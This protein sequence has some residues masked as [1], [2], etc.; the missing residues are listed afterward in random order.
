[1]RRMFLVIILILLPAASWGDEYVLVM[2][3]DD[4]VC[5]NMLNLYN[6]DLRKYGE[7]QYN[8][9]IEFTSIKWKEKHFFSIHNGRKEYTRVLMSLFD[10]NNDEKGE[11]VLKW[12]SSLQSSPTDILYIFKNEDM[13]YFKDEFD[14]KEM[15]RAVSTLGLGGELFKS[16]AYKLKELPKILIDIDKENYYILG[17]LFFFHPFVY[18]G[19][20]YIEMR[21]DM[22]FQDKRRFLVILTYTGDNQLKDT[23]YYLRAVYRKQR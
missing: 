16:N 17:G 19:K 5:Q 18:K 11:S 6:E 22:V 23:C 20:Y 14:V 9:H 8:K 21:D 12:T 10:I 1:M 3:K 2:S 15:H 7:I 4:N 13:G